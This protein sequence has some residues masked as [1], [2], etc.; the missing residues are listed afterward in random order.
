M[1][2]SVG[3]VTQTDMWTAV[4]CLLWITAEE[5]ITLMM[6]S[7]VGRLENIDD[8]SD[9]VVFSSVNAAVYE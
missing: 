8:R 9:R 5:E 3:G 6:S 7:E 2:S 4:S 1:L